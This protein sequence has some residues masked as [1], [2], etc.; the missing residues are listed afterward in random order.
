MNSLF[1]IASLVV[2]ILLL[3]LLFVFFLK[4]GKKRIYKPK[5]AYLLSAGEKIFF[6][7][8]QESITPD[9]YICPKVRI[10]DLV[11]MA[12]DKTD[13]QFWSKFNQI[14]Q[15][16]VDFVICSRENFHPLLIVEL[17]GGS[18]NEQSRSLRDILVDNVFKDAEIPM[19]HFKVSHMYQREA[20]SQQIAEVLSNKIE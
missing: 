15:K 19:L 13:P 2:I 9:M 14:S 20:L 7:A 8:L 17:D 5:G 1:A 10:A 11:E 16:H 4:K 12:I 3:G 6:D 18:H